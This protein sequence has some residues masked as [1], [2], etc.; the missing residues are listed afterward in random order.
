MGMTPLNT[1][2]STQHTNLN[3]LA[4]G[5]QIGLYCISEFIGFDLQ[6]HTHTHTHTN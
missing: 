3:N 6:T 2:Y 4:R 5:L 1:T